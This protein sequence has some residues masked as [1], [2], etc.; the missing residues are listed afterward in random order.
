A[1]QVAAGAARDGA[2]RR[3]GHDRVERGTPGRCDAARGPRGARREPAGPARHRLNRWNINDLAL[4]LTPGDKPKPGPIVAG[5]S[6]PW[7]DRKDEDR[8]WYAPTAALV[9]PKAQETDPAKSPFRFTFRTVGHGPQGRPALQGRVRVTLEWAMA[10]D[11][12]AEWERMGS[13]RATPVPVEHLSVELLVPYRDPSGAAKV[14]AIRAGS[15]KPTDR[16]VVATIELTDEWARVAYGALAVPGFQERPAQVSVAYTFGGW[17]AVSPGKV[18]GAAALH[19]APVATAV[20][21]DRPLPV[22]NLSVIRPQVIIRPEIV[23]ALKKRRYGW[24]T[25]GRAQNLELS[26]PCATFGALYVEETE[27]GPRAVGCREA[28]QLGQAPSRIYERV[29]VAAAPAGTRVLRVLTSPGRFVV[30]PAAYRIGR[31]EAGEAGRAYRPAITLYSTIDADQPT[32]IQC[33]LSAG[34]QPDLPPDR[35]LRIEQELRAKHHPEPVIEHVT[36]LP[37]T[38]TFDWALPQST[39]GW[40]AQVNAV[41]SWDGFHVTVTTNAAG[42][43][44]LQAIL[45]H[46]G[47]HGSAGLTLADGTVLDLTLDLQLSKIVGPWSTGP[48]S[49]ALDGSQALLRNEIDTEVAVSDMI[50]VGAGG[51]VDTVPVEVTLAPHAQHSVALAQGATQVI[52]VSSVRPTPA[53][54][55]EIRAY[56]EDISVEVIFVNLVDLAARQLDSIEV[57]AG[58]RGLGGPQSAVFTGDGT[59][60]PMRFVLALTA[61][62]ADPVLEYRVTRT[63]GPSAGTG[64]LRTWQLSTQGHVVSLTWEQ[65]S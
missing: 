25:H 11:T 52:P 57:T 46:S 47:I 12:K 35:R 64:E 7:R 33:V 20:V 32:N 40:A 60:Q 65:I 15:V 48:V 56:V 42:I 4:D 3:Q 10:A 50:V 61:L 31:Y 54:L 44:A 34:L 16:G 28:Y 51:A 58:I 49:A 30:V 24:R 19:V 2:R 23:A 37:A 55:A 63:G 18:H 39:G 41:R 53:S 14:Q 8:F 22:P 13:P 29:D 1:Q 27:T 5:E 45:A 26:L 21:R 62:A 9:A 17:V 43:L 36:E 6:G 59:A 38:V